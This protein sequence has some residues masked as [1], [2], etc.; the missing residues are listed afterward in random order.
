MRSGVLFGVSVGPGDPELITVKAIKTIERC[1]V[2]AVPQTKGENHLA[3]EIVRGAVNLKNKRI[4][5]LPFLMVRDHKRLREQHEKLADLIAAD[6]ERGEDV[7]MLNL[8]DVSIYSTFSYLRDILEQRGFVCEAI[9]GVPSFCAVAAKL[10]VSLTRAHRPVHI[11]PAGYT[12]TLETL[13]LPGSKILMKAGQAL[14]EVQAAL[15]ARGL[16]KKAACVQ[17]CG[18]ANERVITDMEMA[19]KAEYFTTILVQE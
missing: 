2:I 11:I 12:E 3:L 5:E 7:A 8:G 15:R 1:E 17:N 13:D 6:L 19:E 16:M 4:L 18:L 10:G 14:P 9:A